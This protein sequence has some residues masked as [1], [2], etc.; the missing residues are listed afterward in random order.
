ME[1]PLFVQ[2]RKI[3]KRKWKARNGVFVVVI[4]EEDLLLPFCRSPHAAKLD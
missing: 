3:R 2:N 4:L 1:V